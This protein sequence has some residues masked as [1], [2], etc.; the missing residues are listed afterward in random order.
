MNRDPIADLRRA[1]A[2]LVE[3]GDPVDAAV[4][5]WLDGVAERM[6]TGGWVSIPER[7]AALKIT[8]AMHRRT[9]AHNRARDNGG[10]SRLGRDGP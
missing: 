2:A 4:G 8:R 9:A 5:A 3:G 10:P 7:N 1:A 6:G